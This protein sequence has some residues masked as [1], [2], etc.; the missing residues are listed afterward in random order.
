MAAV[1][2]DVRKPEVYHGKGIRYKGETI[3]LRQP[4]S[5]KKSSG[6]K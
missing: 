6:G 3:S 5:A 4:A 2:R 1:I